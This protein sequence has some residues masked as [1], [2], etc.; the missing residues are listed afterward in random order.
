MSIQERQALKQIQA[1]AE[2]A[3]YAIVLSYSINPTILE[4]HIIGKVKDFRVLYSFRPRDPIR[5]LSAYNEKIK[6]VEPEV[7]HVTYEVSHG[8]IYLFAREQGNFIN[9]NVIIGSFNLMP[10]DRIELF[11]SSKGKIDKK[12]LNKDNFMKI[13]ELPP[14]ISQLKKAFDGDVVSLQALTLL[15]THWHDR[16]LFL[17]HEGRRKL[18]TT[19]DDSL[20]QS[21]ISL[22]SEAAKE[23][24]RKKKSIEFLFAVPFHTERG[25]QAL[26]S[27]II[28]V[29][30]DLGSKV[31]FSV[32]LLTNSFELIH[33]KEK[34]SFTNPKKLKELVEDEDYPLKEVRFWGASRSD[35][36]QG[37]GIHLKAYAI[38]VGDQ[39]FSLAGSNNL[40][41]A[42]WGFD[43]KNLEVAIVEQNTEGARILWNTLEW[44]WEN[45]VTPDNNRW[46]TL[47]NWYRREWEEEKPEGF[48]VEGIKDIIFIGEK[49][50]VS[51]R[52]RKKVRIEGYLSFASRDLLNRRLPFVK[53][54]EAFTS[55]FTL[56]RKHIG[57]MEIVLYAETESQE[58]IRVGRKTVQVKERFPKIDV[59]YYMDK[60]ENVLY[61]NLRIQRG[62]G[63]QEITV[64][65]LEFGEAKPYAF[66]MKDTTKERVIKIYLPVKPVELFL[67]AWSHKISVPQKTGKNPFSE[68]QRTLSIE[69]ES[70]SRTLC[71]KKEAFFR[72]KCDYSFL[73][74]FKVLNLKCF[75]E[76]Y[77]FD[78]Y[79]LSE[80]V[81]KTEQVLPLTPKIK[82][83]NK[84]GIPTKV[85]TVVC[86]FY[87]QSITEGDSL[88]LIPLGRKQYKIYRD[89]PDI[90][91]KLSVPRSNV[92]EL[93]VRFLLE[94]RRDI[95]FVEVET[96]FEG[97]KP[98]KVILYEKGKPAELEMFENASIEDFNRGLIV[99]A[100]FKFLFNIAD[101]VID[102]KV[103]F[104][105]FCDLKSEY[106]IWDPRNPTLTL[107]RNPHFTF[108]I[109]P[110][111]CMPQLSFQ[112]EEGTGVVEFK[113]NAVSLYFPN[114]LSKK[115]E[116]EGNSRLSYGTLFF[117]TDKG[118]VSMDLLVRCYRIERDNAA[119]TIK[120]GYWKGVVV[121]G[122]EGEEPP[123]VVDVKAKE[124]FL[125]Y[126]QKERLRLQ[127]KGHEVNEI[128]EIIRSVMST[129]FDAKHETERQMFM[130]RYGARSKERMLADI[131]TVKLEPSSKVSLL[132]KDRA[133][134]NTR[135]GKA[136][137]LGKHRSARVRVFQI[138]RP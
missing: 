13:F 75:R 25:I 6:R 94:E 83:S 8:K 41:E 44:M 130:K 117:H 77:Y 89:P 70:D 31:P 1:L 51:V 98:N 5:T 92:H 20:K 19:Y 40:T 27:L 45:E 65:D 2:N 56:D 62:D 7:S 59:T 43:G 112:V 99:K 127:E 24:E 78:Y 49:V 30:E 134:S 63:I 18:V 100:R 15:L 97:K 74:R 85:G 14:N 76:V 29:M 58:Y 105:Y 11:I 47:I 10:Q 37:W 39:Y 102:K 52:T 131:L 66:E 64:Q 38:K 46:L 84:L 123:S 80:S 101:E 55:S 36:I 132:V 54:N 121:T 12:L 53:H 125:E 93:K 28:R 48:L 126:L 120:G 23:A 122:P 17:R 42:G 104:H 50:T 72:L 133:I 128:S 135:I 16:P 32:N 69:L 79:S 110:L 9:L 60:E 71:Q 67:E 22:V 87:A 96:G 34:R 129:K 26:T 82:L 119:P 124:L 116:R 118:E 86:N 114:V 95:D 90:T 91:L 137:T 136:S 61:V 3:D 109:T 88:L 106:L 103:K 68:F 4:Q 115:F 108:R 33:E 138:E 73:N 107:R 21:F 35:E 113:K 57:R 111:Q 81:L